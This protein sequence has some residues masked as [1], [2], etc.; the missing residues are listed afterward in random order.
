MIASNQRGGL[1]VLLYSHD[2]VGLG[3]T[4]RNQ[5]I[6]HCLAEHLDDPSILMVT[7][8]RESTLF[9]VPECV[10]YVTVPSL[11]KV[12]GEYVPRRCKLDTTQLIAIRSELLLSVVQSFQPHAL[13]VDK[14][15]SGVCGELGPALRYLKDAG[16]TKCILGLRDILDDAAT[17]RTEWRSSDYDRWIDDH[18]DAVWIYGDRRTYDHSVEY[19][20]SASVEKKLHYIGYLDKTYGG[21]KCDSRQPISLPS[22]RKT[23]VCTVGGGEDGALIAQAFA[24]TDFPS[25]YIGIIVTGP[26]MPPSC[27]REINR[28]AEGN[29]RLKV[30]EFLSEPENLINRA[31]AVVSMCGYNT[32]CEILALRKPALIVPRVQPRTEQLIRALRLQERG[33]ITMK[34]PH[35]FDSATVA[36]WLRSSPQP[37][38][39]VHRYLDLNG[40]TRLPTA[41]LQLMQPPRA[42]TRSNVRLHE[43]QRQS[44]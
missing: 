10:D 15:P 30:V 37:P 44:P 28:L 1:R 9:D 42:Y 20:Y 17:V 22:N 18:Y 40:M 2:T 32:A 5:S 33:L 16:S 35:D 38:T 19:G 6:A 41:L 43:I 27:V 13:I 23:V 39:A 21:Q 12:N 29:S 25:D 14:V 34:H 7:G 24:A 31:D 11:K 26:Y 3:H 4:R 8:A 36:K